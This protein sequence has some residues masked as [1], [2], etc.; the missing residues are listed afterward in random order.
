[1]GSESG[2]GAWRLVSGEGRVQLNFQTIEHWNDSLPYGTQLFVS[3][4]SLSYSL[5]D[6][7]EER[8]ISFERRYVMNTDS[9]LAWNLFALASFG[10]VSTINLMTPESL[11]SFDHTVSSFFSFL[12]EEDILEEVEAAPIK[13]VTAWQQIEN[14]KSSEQ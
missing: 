1:M 7:D 8:R 3:R 12:E 11:P 14:K 10:T 13:Q 9:K 4:N 2:R 6:P 5:G